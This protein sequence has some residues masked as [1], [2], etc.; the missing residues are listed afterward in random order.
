LNSLSQDQS[1]AR[2]KT[3]LTALLLSMF[4]PLTTGIAV[5]LS[6]STTQVADFIRRTVELGALFVAWFVFRRITRKNPS[7]DEKAR[8]EVIAGLTTAGALLL[9]GVV[10][11]G[12]ALSRLGSFEPGGN[13]YPGIA[14]A[15]L[16]LIFNS[17]FWR[18]YSR[19]NREQYSPIM[20]TQRNLYRA[21][22]FVDLCVLAALSAVAISPEHFFTRYIDLLGSAAVFLYL[23]WSGTVSARSALN[24]TPSPTIT[25]LKGKEEQSQ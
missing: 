12:L 19:Y 5:L 24:L 18:R 3:L 15:G 25:A 8:L 10:V 6:T 7:K 20:E 17:W 14:I 4:A 1:A 2:Q 21:K 13:V 16:G 11:L 9:S 22:A 23:L